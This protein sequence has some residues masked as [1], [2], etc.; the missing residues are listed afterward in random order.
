LRYETKKDNRI[1]D[2]KKLL[3][4]KGIKLEQLNIFENII[5]IAGVKSRKNEI[6]SGFLNKLTNIFDISPT[7]LKS[8]SDGTQTEP[9]NILVQHKP[10]VCDIIDQLS[11]NK[12]NPTKFPIKV[13][14]S[15]SGQYSRAIVFMI[16]GITYGEI[17]KI[18]LQSKNLPFEVVIGSTNTINS[19]QFI[20]NLNNVA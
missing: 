17:E 5:K 11:K 7:K 13:L 4:S 18:N 3:L 20:K 9:V 1:E 12:L 14:N 8:N 19:K 6:F 2:I 10:L 16:G 15:S